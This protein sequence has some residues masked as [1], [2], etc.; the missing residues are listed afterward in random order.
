MRVTMNKIV[1][2]KKMV[3]MMMKEKVMVTM[4]R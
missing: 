2:V 1:M 3:T 4:V